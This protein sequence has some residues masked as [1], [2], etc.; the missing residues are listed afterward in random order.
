MWLLR[1]FSVGPSKE[2]RLPGA[3]ASGIEDA[4]GRNET[5]ASLVLGDLTS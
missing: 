2:A 3:W 4:R 5:A 1:S